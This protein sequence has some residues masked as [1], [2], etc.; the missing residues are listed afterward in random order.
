MDAYYRK[1]RRPNAALP[2]SLKR[3]PP[4]TELP[5]HKTTDT[6]PNKPTTATQHAAPVTITKSTRS[7]ESPAKTPSPQ[8]QPRPTTPKKS[9]LARPQQ[10]PPVKR[11][12]MP[13]DLRQE[14]RPTRTIVRD[15]F[16]PEHPL[17]GDEEEIDNAEKQDKININNNNDEGSS[18]NNNQTTATTNPPDLAA[19]F[20]LKKLNLPA[21]PPAT[22]VKQQVKRLPEPQSLCPESPS[23]IASGPLRGIST[24]LL[25]LIRAKEAKAKE[26][27]PEQLRQRE[28]LG[29][30]PEIARIVPTVFTANRKEFML[31]DTVVEK[32]FKGLKSNYTTDTIIEC[33]D[34][35][36]KVAPEWLSTVVISRGR[37]LRLN[38]ERYTLPQLLKAIQRFKS[39]KGLAT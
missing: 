27:S 1:A 15:L 28:L 23:K 5:S 7:L 9:R 2:N 13:N 18:N 26:I 38:Q 39:E 32:C 4:I 6:T 30:A 8:P 31:Y 22:P 36:K 35:M 3:P 19:A 21:T 37:F 12:L 24:S 33:L 14:R 10:A 34:L 16:R 29:I 17:E 25:D 20:G 11:K